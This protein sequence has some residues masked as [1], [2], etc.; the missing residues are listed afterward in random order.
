[1]IEPDFA[2]RQRMLAQHGFAQGVEIGFAGALHIHG[3]DAVGRTAAGML[4]T[5]RSHGAEVGTLHRRHHDQTDPRLRGRRGHGSTVVV[6]LGGIQMAMGVDQHRIKAY[7]EIVASG[8][9]RG[10]AGAQLPEHMSLYVSD[11]EH[12]PSPDPVRA[13]D[14]FMSFYSSSSIQACC[15]AS[16]FFSPQ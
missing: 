10:A 7:E 3:V 2:H 14:L 12:R 11:S 6:K 5:D 15:I 16:S 9:Q 8:P 13:V 4:A 1:M